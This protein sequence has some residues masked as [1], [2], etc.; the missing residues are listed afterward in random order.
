MCS[1]QVW[2]R[3]IR[4]SDKTVM[5]WIQR[6]GVETL[7]IQDKKWALWALFINIWECESFANH[8][9]QSTKWKILLLIE[10]YKKIVCFDSELLPHSQISKISQELKYGFITSFRNRSVSL[11]STYSTTTN[12]KFASIYDHGWNMN[13]SLHSGIDNEL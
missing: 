11:C 1:C 3:V 13:P 9:P 7:T 12:Q 10:N 5:W 6:V 8:V 4:K 2:L